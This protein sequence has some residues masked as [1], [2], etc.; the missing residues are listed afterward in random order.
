LNKSPIPGNPTIII[1]ED[2]KRVVAQLSEVLGGGIVGEDLMHTVYDH[3]NMNFKDDDFVEIQD[4][5]ARLAR[6]FDFVSYE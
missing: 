3:G 4:A 1:T 6:T 2:K 5:R